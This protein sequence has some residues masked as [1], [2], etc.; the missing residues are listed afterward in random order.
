VRIL[1]AMARACA[2]LGAANVTVSCIVERS[3]VSRR[4]FYEQF[5]DRQEC[6]LASID[7]ALQRASLP[8]LAAY[9]PVQGWRERLRAA[10]IA[11]LRFIEEEPFAGRLVVV[12]TL[13]SGR[14]ALERR[15][16]VLQQVARA[17]DEGRR[18]GKGELPPLTAEGAVGGALAVLHARLHDDRTGSLV[19]LT[20]PLMSILTLPYL[21]PSAARRE[22]DRPL[23]EPLSKSELPS[24]GLLQKPTMRLTYRTIRVLAA[25]AAEPDASNR[26]LASK[27][28]VQDQGQISKLLTRLERL[29]LIENRS[30]GHARGVPNAW[31]LTPKGAAIHRTLGER[32]RLRPGSSVATAP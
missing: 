31:R 32:T 17:V 3:G 30:G 28:G 13:G 4:T 25:M 16:Q 2:E 27:A 18:A 21:G 8:V 29:E 26:D 5:R 9:R 23:P 22:L 12:E 14:E 15:R 7:D 24:T 6:L 10:L 11:F 19:E 20:G 1:D